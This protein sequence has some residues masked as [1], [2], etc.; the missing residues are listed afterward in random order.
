MFAPNALNG[1]MDRMDTFPEHLSPQYEKM[2]SSSFFLSQQLFGKGL[3][4]L[5]LS[6]FDKNSKNNKF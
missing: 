3:H 5:H 4:S 6:I 1:E 2:I